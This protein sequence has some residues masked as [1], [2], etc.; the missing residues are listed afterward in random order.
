M[1]CRATNSQVCETSKV[2]SA[3]G[4]AADLGDTEIIVKYCIRRAVMCGSTGQNG[5]Q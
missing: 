4:P 1:A 3:Q 5:N 2:C